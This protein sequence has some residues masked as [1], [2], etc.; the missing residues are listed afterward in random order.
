MLLKVT[1]SRNKRRAR[2]LARSVSKKCRYIYVSENPKRGHLEDLEVNVKTILRKRHRKRTCLE[3]VNMTD[4]AE[5]GA[6][7]ELLKIQNFWSSIVYRNFLRSQK[8]Y[9]F[10]RSTQPHGVR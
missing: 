9:C 8:Y 4:L 6:S 7:S 10:A 2:N 1:K 5:L 3:N